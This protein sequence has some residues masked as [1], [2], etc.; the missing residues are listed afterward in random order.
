MQAVATLSLTQAVHRRVARL[1]GNRFEISVVGDDASWAEDRIDNAIA[2]I[3]RVEK[4]LSLN[5]SSQTSQINQYAGIKPVKVNGEIFKLISR[6]IEISALTNGAFDITCGT[7]DKI[8]RDFYVDKKLKS[9]NPINYKNIVLDLANNTVFLKEKG[10]RI[11]FSRVDKGYAADRAK[12]VLQLQGVSSGVINVGGDL[13]AWGLQPNSEPW[14]LADADPSQSAKPFA[15]VNVSNM[16]ITTL[17]GLDEYAV[18]N[19]KKYAGINDAE[20]GLFLRGIKSVSMMSP[21]AELADAMATPL[22]L[23]GTKTGMA[24]INKLQQVACVFIDK[25]NHMH[26]SKGVDFIN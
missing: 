23:M 10:M 13:I 11:D 16:A 1:M 2:E 7:V 17:G 4:M 21:S 9:D 14:T 24:L 12:Y 5:E 20:T 15:N 8:L 3:R 25:N 26:T 19:G 22:M 6:S 18:V